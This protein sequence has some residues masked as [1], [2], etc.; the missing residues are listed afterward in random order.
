MYKSIQETPLKYRDNLGQTKSYISVSKKCSFLRYETIKNTLGQGL[1][2]IALE[3]YPQIKHHIDHVEFATPL[4]N[5]HYFGQNF[6]ESFGM[7]A[8]GERYKDPL[9]SAKLRAAT[10]I[11]G[12]YLSGQDS[13]APGIYPGFCSGVMTASYIL[14]RNLFVDL[15]WLHMKNKMQLVFK[16]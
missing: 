16:K 10:D 8:S 11:P 15:L 7:K 14:E 4:T 9:L 3:V 12:L 2:D 1:V 6:G 5:N 13:L